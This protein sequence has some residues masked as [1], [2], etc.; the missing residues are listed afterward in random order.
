[1]LSGEGSL[2]C[3]W[4]QLAGGKEK[5]MCCPTSGAGGAIP[6]EHSVL[7]K[8]NSAGACCGLCSSFFHPTR[9]LSCTA[10]WSFRAGISN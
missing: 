8:W 1:M 7:T 3:A 2:G 10:E 4:A 6:G 5:Y 9:M